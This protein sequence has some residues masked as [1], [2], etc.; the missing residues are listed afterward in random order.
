MHNKSLDH[1]QRRRF[2]LLQGLMGPFFEKIGTA[3]REKQHDVWKINFNGGDC[4]FWQLPNGISF[5]GTDTEWPVFLLNALDK[6]RITDII[7]FGDCRPLHRTAIKICQ[8]LK[9]RIYVFEEGY[10]R[11][12]WV[13]LERDGVNGHSTL[14]RNSQWYIEQ[15]RHFP[16]LPP[17]KTVPSSFKRR[18]LEAVAYNAADILTRWHFRHWQDYRPWGAWYEG[19]SWLR[20][21]AKKKKALPRSQKLFA[22]LEETGTP[23]MLFPLQL[24][25]DSQI[26]L[27]S[28]FA[29][30][31]PALSMVMISFA[32]H[33]PK[34]LYLV[35]KEHPLDNGVKNWCKLVYDLAKTLGISHRVIYME[36]GD[37]AHIVAKAQGVVTINSTTG[38]LALANNVPV[39]VLGRAVYNV[40][41]VT[42]QQP[43]DTFWVTP[44]SPDPAA[45][46]AFMT[47][48]VNRCLIEGGFFSDE[49]LDSLVSGALKRIQNIRSENDD[50]VF[51]P[52][53]L[54]E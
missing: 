6:L 16:P 28:D 4:L 17:H 5:T 44:R 51:L 26:H 34:N 22:W 49:G 27:H 21:L 46:Q 33:A 29:G 14:P 48:L 35:I 12:D 54:E 20:R 7:L 13:T 30:M 43:L 23:Y 40:D 18:A 45:L 36:Y 41:H 52:S 25:A 8:E 38:T 1:S 42:D 31:T 47:V 50:V 19:M 53:H 24:D 37:I 32:K 3:L 9:I 10:I 15:A 11:P 2:L 39:K